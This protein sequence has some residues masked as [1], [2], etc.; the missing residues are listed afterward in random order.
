MTVTD[1]EID[2]NSWRNEET[3]ASS[4]F[5]MADVMSDSLAKQIPQ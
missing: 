3:I 1:C 4:M 2:H 5:L